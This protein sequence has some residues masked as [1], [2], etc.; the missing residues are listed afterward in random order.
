MAGSFGDVRFVVTFV[1]TTGAM[2]FKAAADCE[3]LAGRMI[4]IP[5]KLHAG[6]GQAW[7]A[8]LTARKQ[9]MALL[10]RPDIEYAECTIFE[11]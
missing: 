6:C 5:Q 9:L 2:A 11:F 8:P 1:N 10:A 3:G 7:S 4:P